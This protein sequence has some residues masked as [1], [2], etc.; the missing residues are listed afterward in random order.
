[1]KNSSLETILT[2]L[3]MISSDA[4]Q[5]D[6]TGELALARNIFEN[7]TR[8]MKLPNKDII[9]LTTAASELALY[10][11]LQHYQANHQASQNLKSKIFS[12]LI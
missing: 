7:I 4:H 5:E 6:K 2:S 1:M 3:A 11:T 8:M 12:Q 10:P 9:L